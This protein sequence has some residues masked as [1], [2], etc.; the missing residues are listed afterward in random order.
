MPCGAAL[1]KGC[2]VAPPAAVAL[3][4][5]AVAAAVRAAVAGDGEKKRL[6]RSDLAAFPRPQ[7]TQGGLRHQIIEIVLGP[8][9]AAQ[10]RAQHRLVRLHAGG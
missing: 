5:V 1:R 2:G 9:S 8:E 10:P 3:G 4:G 7:E 6:G